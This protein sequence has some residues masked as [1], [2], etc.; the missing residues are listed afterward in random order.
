MTTAQRFPGF[1]DVPT[2]AEAGFPGFAAPGWY[3]LVG[4]VG[5]PD[6]VVQRLHDATVAVL[7]QDGIKE[8]LLALGS[9]GKS[10]SPTAITELLAADVKRWGDVLQKGNIERI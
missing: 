3:G 6:A 7:A 4:P 5:M 9:L 2:V 10:S 8:R 1:E